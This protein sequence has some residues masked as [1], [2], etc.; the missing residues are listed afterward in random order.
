[1]NIDVEGKELEVLKGNDWNKFRSKVILVEIIGTSLEEIFK[2]PIC[3]FLSKNNYS[4]FAKTFNTY[5]FIK[6][7]FVELSYDSCPHC[8]FHI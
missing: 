2:N 7:N 8:S 4:F 5:F 3:N 6:L 1:M